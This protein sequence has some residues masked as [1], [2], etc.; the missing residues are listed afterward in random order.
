MSTDYELTWQGPYR[1]YVK[2]RDVFSDMPEAKQPGIY[3]WTVSIEKENFVYYVGETH[4]WFAER[5]SE[6]ARGYFSGLYRVYDAEQFAQGKRFLVWGGTLHL[7]TKGRE[8]EFLQM[9]SELEPRIYELLNL[10]KIFIAPLDVEDHIRQRIEAAIAGKLYRTPG[11]A[12]AF[13]NDDIQYK[14]KRKGE[15]TLSITMK[16]PEPVVGLGDDLLA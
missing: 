16:F 12:G 3:L 6:H 1:W 4:N 5:F 9:F 8:E 11:I 2:E 14:E 15:A 7:G 10:F 13:Q